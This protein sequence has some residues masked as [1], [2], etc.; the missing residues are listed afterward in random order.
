E[1]PAPE[2]PAPEPP[3]V[4]YPELARGLMRVGQQAP[5]LLPGSIVGRYVVH[6]RI[7]EGDLGTVY[8]VHD[9]RLGRAVALEIWRVTT[10]LPA[11]ASPPG[12]RFLHEARRL[13]K[14]SHP[15]VIA[16][17]D[18]GA[19]GPDVYVTMEIAQGVPLG[20]W[21]AAAP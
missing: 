11:A 15:N 4:Q 19:V 14:L 16:I 6:S 8:R 2:P 10:R 18:V 21:L 12:M 3:A 5:P 1:P 7:R 13:A 9:P 20:R 17:H